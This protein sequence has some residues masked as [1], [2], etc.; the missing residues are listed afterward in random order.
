MA[1]SFFQPLVGSRGNRREGRTNDKIRNFKGKW[2]LRL[3]ELKQF[4]FVGRGTEQ[5]R[6]FTRTFLFSSIDA[7]HWQHVLLKLIK[8]K[9]LL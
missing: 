9:I 5:Y 8:L 1:V 4:R 7:Y 6:I 2:K 3:D